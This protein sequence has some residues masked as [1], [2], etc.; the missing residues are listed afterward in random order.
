MLGWCETKS[1]TRREFIE[2]HGATCQNW[3][4]SWSFINKAERFIIFGAW[5]RDTK[6]R[7]TRIFSEDWERPRGRKSAG[8]AQSREHIRL[9]EEE[10]FRLKTFPMQRFDIGDDDGRRK[11]AKI[12]GFTPELTERK[13]VRA[14]P[15]WFAID[16]NII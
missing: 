5:D 11:R 8:Y 7:T 2:S 6:G 1:M 13:L 12:G 16:S 14:G 3:Q 15:D 9:L 4:W 10:R